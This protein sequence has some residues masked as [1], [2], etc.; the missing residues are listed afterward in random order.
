MKKFITL[1]SD[2]FGGGIR[3]D[4]YFPLLP[5]RYLSLS[6]MLDK[7]PSIVYPSSFARYSESGH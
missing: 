5:F 6:P 3:R 4:P 1:G 2:K 7:Q